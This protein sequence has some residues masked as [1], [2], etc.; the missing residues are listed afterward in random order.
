MRLST[1]VKRLERLGVNRA[2]VDAE[3]RV[4]A[5]QLDRLLRPLGLEIRR[6][7][8]R[9]LVRRGVPARGDRRD[10]GSHS[11]REPRPGPTSPEAAH[12]TPSAGEASQTVQRPHRTR[13]RVQPG[14]TSS[15]PARWRI[16]VATRMAG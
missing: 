11:P 9:T 2:H 12:P 5:Q 4:V 15:S 8:R 3:T 6:L 10:Y 7:G 13:L 1:V 16:R 14:G